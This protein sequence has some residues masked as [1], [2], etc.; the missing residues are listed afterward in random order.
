MF[1]RASRCLASLPARASG[2]GGGS[3]GHPEIYLFWGGCL[4][5]G[6]GGERWLES[7]TTCMAH[8]FTHEAPGEGQPN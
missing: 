1:T 8:F 4:N 6:L 5:K 7:V 2:G 3:E